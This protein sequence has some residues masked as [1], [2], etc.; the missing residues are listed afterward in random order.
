MLE[1]TLKILQ[2]V[3]AEELLLEV[4]VF[5]LTLH[6]EKVWKTSIGQHSNISVDTQITYITLQKEKSIAQE[7]KYNKQRKKNRVNRI[8]IYCMESWKLI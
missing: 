5:E 1:N 6:V 8:H 3:E 2:K 4:I 7:N